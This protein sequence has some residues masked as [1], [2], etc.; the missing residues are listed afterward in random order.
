MLLRLI[1]LIKMQI[2]INLMIVFNSKQINIFLKIVN[3]LKLK[4][5]LK[6]MNLINKII[7]TKGIYKIV[8]ERFQI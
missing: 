2:I 4:L 8:L 1:K 3:N 7:S 5:C 6:L